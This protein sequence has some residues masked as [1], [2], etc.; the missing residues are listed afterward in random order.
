MREER[1]KLRIELDKEHT[2]AMGNVRLFFAGE[3]DWQ[4]NLKSG[5]KI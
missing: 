2:T 1:K 4:N 3:T 5:W